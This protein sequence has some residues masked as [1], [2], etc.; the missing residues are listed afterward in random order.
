MN[1][2]LRSFNGA[3]LFER[4]DTLD[5]SAENVRLVCAVARRRTDASGFN[6]AALF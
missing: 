2:A 6:G 5:T 4:G 3:A 1:N